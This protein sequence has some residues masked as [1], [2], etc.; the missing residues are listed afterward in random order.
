MPTLSHFAFVRAGP[1]ALIIYFAYFAYF[2]V[3]SLLSFGCGFAALGSS[4]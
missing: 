3:K 1:L 4:W 2:A